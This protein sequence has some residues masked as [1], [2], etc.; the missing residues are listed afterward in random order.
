MAAVY[1]P[2]S[3]ANFFAKRGEGA[4]YND[5]KIS[6]SQ[7]KNIGNCLI[8]ADYGGDREP[9]NLEKKINNVHRILEKARG[10][11]TMGSAAMHCCYIASG[12]ADG[13]FEFG[14]HCWDYAA[15]YLIA[16]EAGAFCQSCDGSEVDLM[17]RN[18]MICS[19]QTLAKELSS[20]ISMVKYPRD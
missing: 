12:W 18:I 1:S 4:F 6:V 15:G 10:V 17:A 7:P 11:R 14:I 3:G 13:F 16:L 20:I 2:V 8:L 19:N 5:K 9:A